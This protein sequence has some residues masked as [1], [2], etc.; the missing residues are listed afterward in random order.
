MGWI[1]RIFLM[2][3]YQQL[4]FFDK[5]KKFLIVFDFNKRFLF[6][7]EYLNQKK[8]IPWKILKSISIIF[9][10]FDFYLYFVRSWN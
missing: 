10:F 2:N 9:A 1:Y 3:K 6:K 7:I 8:L 5:Y 4:F